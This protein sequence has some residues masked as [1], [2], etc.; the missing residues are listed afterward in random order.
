MAGLPAGVL[1]DLLEEGATGEEFFERP[2][3]HGGVD[4]AERHHRMGGAMFVG[5]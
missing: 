5:R 2:H 3:H 1:E 4:R